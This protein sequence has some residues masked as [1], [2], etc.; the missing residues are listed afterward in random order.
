MPSRLFGALVLIFAT[1]LL[2][3]QLALA[4]F[5]Q[6]GPPLVGTG[7]YSV[8]LSADGNTAL[9]GGNDS[10][11]GAAWV[12]TRSNGV[13]TQE[14]NKLVPTS[15][16]GVSTRSIGLSADGNT[17][18]MGGVD[19]HSGILAAWVFT[20]SGGVWT[21][22]GNELV[23]TGAAGNGGGNSPPPVALSADGNTA[24]LGADSSSPPGAAWVFTRT[25][26]VWTQQG[27]E[28]VHRFLGIDHLRWIHV[29]HD[30]LYPSL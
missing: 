19:L 16:N 5:T 14:G 24:I 28:L 10:S 12:F 17:A 15:A 30:D 6:Q 11:P 23:G 1:L 29:I 20:R 9:L 22:Q 7:G 27:N 8:A 18:I 25:N 21:Q 3:S 26:G 2:S 4:Q 13:W